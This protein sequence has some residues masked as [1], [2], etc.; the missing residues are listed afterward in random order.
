M[1]D[2]DLLDLF[3]LSYASEGGLDA[4]L[5]RVLERSGTWFQASGVSIFLREGAS[6]VFRV[7][8]A[9][10]TESRSPEDATIISGQGIAGTCIQT[11]QPLLINDPA[12]HPLLA[13]K[14]NYKRREQYTAMVV[15][16]VVPQGDVIGVLNLSRPANEEFGEGDLRLAK[17]LGNNIALAVSNA[18]LLDGLN[19]ALSANVAVRQKL[20][21]VIAH[22]GVGIL[23]LDKKGTIT[24]WNDGAYA[25]ASDEASARDLGQYIA[26]APRALKPEIEEAF[27]TSREGEEYQARVRDDVAGHT[28]SLVASPMPDGGVTLVLSD[29]TDHERAL[30]ELDRVRRLAEIGQMTAAIAHEIRN[31]L[32]SICSAAQFVQSDVESAVEFGAIIEKEALKLN[33]LCDEFLNFAKP[34]ELNL[35]PLKLNQLVQEVAS[36]HAFEFERAGVQLHIE[37]DGAE[38]IIMGDAARL[39]Q[40]CRNLILNALQASKDGDK[41]EVVVDGTGF[42]VKDTGQGMDISVQQNLFTPFFTTKAKGTG[43]GL[44]NVKKIVDA[45]HGRIDLSSTPNRGTTFTVRLEQRSA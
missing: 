33:D 31:P 28:W 16:L 42:S 25:F 20:Q 14:I 3:D 15:P 38:P 13:G 30:Q 1:Q 2:R 40:A 36:G 24:E 34:L 5:K 32:A 27:D 29:V 18:R 4:Y 37:V 23:V 22:A 10:G 19:D 35:R 44:S 12:D 6:D 41:V 17:T 7:A 43:L 39:E 21:S 26:L 11:K 45:H 8:A 9:S